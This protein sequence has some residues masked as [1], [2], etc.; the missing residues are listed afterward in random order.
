VDA[1]TTRAYPKKKGK[2]RPLGVPTWK[3]KLVQEVIRSILETYYDQQL[4]S[5]SHGFRPRR[6]CH[7]AL[8][9]IQQNWTGVKWFIEGDIAQYFD[10]INHEV[11]I[12][13]LSGKIHDEHF[14]QFVRELLK[15]GYLED[16]TY[17][18]TI[19]G[20]PQGGVI[21]P[22]LSNLYLDKLDR[23]IEEKLIPAYTRGKRR[24]P[25]P[26]YA[27]VN[28]K[29]YQMKKTGQTEGVKE[30]VQQR[31]AL[32]SYDY[33]DPAYRRLKFVR[34]AD[35]FLIGYV[36]TRQEA[37]QIKR[38]LGEFLQKTLKLTLS[39]EKTLITSA[40][41]EAARFLGYHIVNQQCQDKITKGRRVVN[42]RIAL[43]VPKDAIDKKC[44]QYIQH[45][46]PRRRA[47]LLEESDYS[48]VNN[49]QQI[50]RGIVQYY[51]LAHNVRDLSKLRWIMLKSLLHTLAN[52]HKTSTETIRKKYQARVQ[53]RKEKSLQCLEVQV[54]REGKEP[55]VARFGGISLTRQPQA[56]LNDHPPIPKGGRTEIIKR[57]LADTCELC[58]ST[59]DIEVHHIRKLADLK[60]KGGRVVPG[61]KQRMA[62][63]RRKT[64]VLCHRCHS[65]LH[66]GKL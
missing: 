41:Q 63:M 65:R 50:Y 49:Y 46:K 34:Y 14:L 3:D 42:G 26:A 9:D 44:A 61:W 35:D 4:S 29:L 6:G 27:K 62:A 60:D 33:H 18:R 59:L 21:S 38:D 30:L 39:D 23:Y 64:L 47:E 40:T 15:A 58:E 54:Q 57:L 19:S 17:H 45:G 32:P 12:E 24:K 48:I 52:K 25:N 28:D 51:L 8:T 16:W 37:E 10:T 1:S 31:R 36:G 20:T 56:N 66:A 2:T 22:L 43:Q 53:T 11:L 55:L 13:I 7:T 5:H